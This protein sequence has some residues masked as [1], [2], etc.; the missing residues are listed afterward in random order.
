MFFILHQIRSFLFYTVRF[1]C[2]G[3]TL[4]HLSQV[5]WP[6]LRN[7]HITCMSLEMW[8]GAKLPEK[9][10]LCRSIL[11]RSSATHY[12]L[13]AT[14]G[15]NSSTCWETGVPPANSCTHGFLTATE[16]RRSYVIL[17]S[18]RMCSHNGSP[19]YIT[20]QG[21]FMCVHSPSEHKEQDVWRKSFPVS[22]WAMLWTCEHYTGSQNPCS[23][24]TLRSSSPTTVS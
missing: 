2:P 24:K 11:G 10:S 13:W 5:A 22:C 17:F 4:Q 3:F 14:E 1:I 23:W 21:G 8:P 12:S 6:V 7:S 15:L 19:L 9:C 18:V 20:G 16:S